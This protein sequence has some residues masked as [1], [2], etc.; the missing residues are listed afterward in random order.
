MMLKREPRPRGL[1]GSKNG[2]FWE[3]SF[4]L[5]SGM[6]LALFRRK[7]CLRFFE[8]ARVR[9]VSKNQSQSEVFSQQ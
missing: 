2:K 3:V 9:I 1:C 5:T 4:W 7:I 6:L 8:P